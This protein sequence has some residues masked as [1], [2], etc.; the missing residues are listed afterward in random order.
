MH[1][2]AIIENSDGLG[3][4]FSNFPGD[5]EFNIF[6]VWKTSRFPDE[7]FDAYILTGDYNNVSDGLLPFHEKEV[8]FLN[9]IKGKRI[10]ASCFAHQLL[11]QVFGGKV[12]KRRTRFFGWQPVFIRE[13]H[14]VFEGL[15]EP[16]F[17]CLNGDEI[18]EKPESAKVLATN[19]ECQYQLLLYGQ[20]TLTCQSHPEILKL[21][22][23]KLINEHR[24]RLSPRCPDLDEIL[25]RTERFADDDVNEAFMGN[26]VE[27]L[28]E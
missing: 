10:F 9:T 6:P 28:V 5:I 24:A 13:E 18:K 20:N 12:E 3:R 4:H 17:L 7:E 26:V 1:K 16:C 22:S 25:D 23:L 15:K 19:P 8:E 14:Q 27:W 11:G 2:I 21:D